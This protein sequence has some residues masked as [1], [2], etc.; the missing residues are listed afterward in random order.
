MWGFGWKLMVSGLL[1][2]IWNQL[3]QVVVGKYYSPHTLGQYTRS[4]AYA[5]IF[6][7]NITVIVQRVSYPVLANIQDDKK[8]MAGA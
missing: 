4:R 6:S 8:K 3:Y 5:D 7:T 1:N 2:S